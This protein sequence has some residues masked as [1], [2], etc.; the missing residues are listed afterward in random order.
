MRFYYFVL[1][2][3]AVSYFALRRIVNSPFGAALEGIRENEPRM[4]SLGY[5]TWLHKYIAFLLAGTFAGLAGVLFAYHSGIMV[6]SNVGVLMSGTAIFVV[7]I[8]G[9]NTLYGALVGSAVITLL[10]FYS[11]EITLER[12][13]LIMGGVFVATIMFARS[14]IGVY[15]LRAWKKVVK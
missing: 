9:I 3:F 1:L 13:P 6:P 4:R 10:Q 8:G 12:W 11:S 5:H 14:G 2:I 7:I 15:L